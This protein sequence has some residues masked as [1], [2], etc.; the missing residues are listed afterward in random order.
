MCSTIWFALIK[1]QYKVTIYKTL[2]VKLSN[3]QL[4]LKPGI[5][6]SAEVLVIFVIVLNFIGDSNDEA[7][8][9]HKSIVTNTKVSRIWKTFA[10]GSSGNT[11]FSKTLTPKMIQLGG[12]FFRSLEL[13]TI[14]LFITRLGLWIHY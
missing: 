14:D 4:N 12:S 13:P 6:N 11:K 9:S 7:N 1:H 5:E 8:F 3:L 10:N 2:N